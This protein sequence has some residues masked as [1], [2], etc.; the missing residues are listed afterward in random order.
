MPTT[1]TNATPPAKTQ[2]RTNNPFAN[3]DRRNP[4]PKT[5]E[6]KAA[7]EAV[8]QAWWDRNGFNTR[9]TA[10][11]LIPLTPGTVPAGTRDCYACE[12]NDR[13]DIR[14]PHRSEDCTITPKIP[15]QERSWCAYCRTQARATA[16]GDQPDGAQQIEEYGTYQ[17][18]TG[19]TETGQGNDGEPTT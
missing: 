10:A 19:Q 15:A 12:Q 13:G 8:I 14:F 7:Y 16:T 17:E 11:D 6:G 9:A 4:Y 5:T 1:R 3:W 18:Q 2:N